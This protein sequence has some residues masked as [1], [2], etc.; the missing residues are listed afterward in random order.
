VDAADFHRVISAALLAR[1]VFPNDRLL[2]G[3]STPAEVRG[4]QRWL[5]NIARVLLAGPYP[6]RR[7]S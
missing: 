4:V 1:L 5:W 6:A 2:R 7:P 3:R